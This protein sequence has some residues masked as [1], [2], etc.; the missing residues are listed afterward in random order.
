[1]IQYHMQPAKHYE[2]VTGTKNCKDLDL[3][4]SFDNVAT[5]KYCKLTK[6][7]LIS[8]IGP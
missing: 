8:L 5:Y 7:V 2:K 3:S 4:A 1:M 6:T